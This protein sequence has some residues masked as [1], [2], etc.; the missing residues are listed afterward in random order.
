MNYELFAL[1]ACVLGLDV[2]VVDVSL[3]E[4]VPSSPT[5]PLS[6]S[7]KITLVDKDNSD[8]GDCSGDVGEA[9]DSTT[10]GG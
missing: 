1:V 6:L 10:T 4:V 7:N 8:G 3:E 5:C 2:F 9:P